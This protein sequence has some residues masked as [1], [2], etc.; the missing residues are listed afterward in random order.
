M[1][2]TLRLAQN[3]RHLRLAANLTQEQIAEVAGMGLKFYQTLE[4]G[5]KAQIKVETV[6]R[7]SKPF[8]L[9]VWQLLAPPSVLRRSQPRFPVP[10][11]ESSRGPRANWKGEKAKLKAR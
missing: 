10:R 3:L 9:E 5:R 7:L 11:T 1:P 4:S 8:G 2:P 6:E